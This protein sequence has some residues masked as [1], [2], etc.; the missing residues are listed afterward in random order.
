MK[1]IIFILSIFICI[2][3][4]SNPSIAQESSTEGT[5]QNRT[6]SVEEDIE[7]I[8]YKVPD[9]NNKEVFKTAVTEHIVNNKGIQDFYTVPFVET[10][11]L[12]SI[13]NSETDWHEKL[14]KLEIAF[15]ILRH[16]KITPASFDGCFPSK[17]KLIKTFV[18]AM[19]KMATRLVGG[20]VGWQGGWGRVRQLTTRHG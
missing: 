4:F 15:Q 2:I 8:F 1:F 6:E 13:I 16:T 19:G 10:K 7:N 3:L 17:S 11:W 9:G 14:Q 12:D 20:Q 5:K 18:T